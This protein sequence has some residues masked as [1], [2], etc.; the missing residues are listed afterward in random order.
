MET[1]SAS[2]TVLGPLIAGELYARN[3]ALPFQVSVV[4]ILLTLPLVWLFAP[5]RD[6]HTVEPAPVVS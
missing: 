2:A 1:V 3:F 6:A 4:L 5:R